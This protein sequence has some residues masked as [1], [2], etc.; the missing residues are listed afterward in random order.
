MRLARLVLP[1]I[2]LL[3]AAAPPAQAYESLDD[4]A[5]ACAD[6]ALNVGDYVSCFSHLSR[7]LVAKDAVTQQQR[8]EAVSQAS[9][10]DYEALEL[11]CEAGAGAG[12]RLVEG[13]GASLET[14]SPFYQA[15]PFTGRAPPARATL[16]QWNFTDRD[17]FQVNPNGGQPECQYSVAIVDQLG[18]A[19]RREFV[20]CGATFHDRDLPAPSEN[21]ADFEVPLETLNAET[22]QPD[23]TPLAP[24]VYRIEAT[25][26]RQGPQRESRPITE[27]GLPRAGVAVRILD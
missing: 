26:S 4:V 14:D 10:V 11:D 19:V 16:R 13:W 15:S 7:R 1:P 22:G 20:T 3:I 25:W 17:A 23:G 21:R 27:G 5:C 2:L 9:S 12:D 18:R 8:A 24:G 6:D